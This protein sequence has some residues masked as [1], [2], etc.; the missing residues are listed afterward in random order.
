VGFSGEKYKRISEIDRV[1]WRRELKLQDE[2]LTALGSR[3]PR[4]L[5]ERR[6]IL[7]RSFA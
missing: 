2:L 3:L 7:G 1:E 6:E 5:A 4:E